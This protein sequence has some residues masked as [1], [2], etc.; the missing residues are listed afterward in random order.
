MVVGFDVEAESADVGALAGLGVDVDVKGFEDAAAT[1]IGEG[2]DALDP[3]EGGVAPIGPFIGDQHLSGGAAGEFGD[4]I[5]AAGRVVEEGADSG[6][7]GVDIESAASVSCAMA[8]LPATRNSVSS[9][10]AWRMVISRMLSAYNRAAREV[11][12]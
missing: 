6:A 9:R 1:G 8:A 5:E 7:E 10:V 12:L 11:H 2:V 3:P 4:Q